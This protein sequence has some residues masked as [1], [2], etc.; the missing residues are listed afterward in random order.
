[1]NKNERLQAMLLYLNK[2]EHF[3]LIDLMNRYEI[4]RSTAIRDI[5]ALETIGLP[6]YSQPGRNGYY[7]ILH[8]RLMSPIVFSND[9]I[10]TLYFAM[11]T[12]YNFQSTPFLS[13]CVN[14]QTKFE[15]CLPPKLLEEIKQ[16]KKIVSF[17][18]TKH[19]HHSNLLPD[20]LQYALHQKVCNVKYEKANQ[21][22]LYSVQFIHIT[23][24]FGQWY[25]TV[26]N[27]QTNKMQVLR[28]DKIKTIEVT[29]IQT[30]TIDPNIVH[31]ASSYRSNL[32]VDFK[33]AVTLK[34]ADIFYKE[35]YPTMKLIKENQQ[36]YVVG[37]YNL[38]EIT[39]ICN[40][41]I[42]FGKE[43]ISIYPDT[44]KQA[45]LKVLH[46]NTTYY[47]HL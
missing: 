10:F 47:L 43:I 3:N 37:Y 39:F 28:C 41:F 35:H 16:M 19:Y 31:Q 9:E 12:L 40:Y 29:S 22:V 26:Y 42:A 17:N 13:D 14:I 32:A 30:P 21:E 8:N 1:M 25:T 4:S 7:G 45:I 15:T 6:I 46:E 20:I 27:I 2:K 18:S 34:G 5:M 38:N 44:L 36:H 33:V 11:L 23:T 24:N